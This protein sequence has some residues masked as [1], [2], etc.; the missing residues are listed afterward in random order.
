MLL[1]KT[2][3]PA[4]RIQSSTRANSLTL[5]KFEKPRGSWIG[6]LFGGEED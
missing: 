3:R 5:K 6:D 2:Q 4:L 1:F